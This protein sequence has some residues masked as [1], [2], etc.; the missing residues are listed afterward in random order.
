LKVPF[1]KLIPISETKTISNHQPKS[2]I[3]IVVFSVICTCR[4]EELIMEKTDLVGLMLAKANTNRGQHA[5]TS[6]CALGIGDM[7]EECKKK[8]EKNCRW[9][10][11]TSQSC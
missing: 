4:N 9:K 7:I 8:G 5:S 10:R 11:R 3:K 2:I 1:P 6:A